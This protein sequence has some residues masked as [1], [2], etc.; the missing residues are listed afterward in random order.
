MIASLPF[1]SVGLCLSLCA[2]SCTRLESMERLIRDESRASH[3]SH[4]SK[5]KDLTPPQKKREKRKHYTPPFCFPEERKGK[6]SFGSTSGPPLILS[7]RI[8]RKEREAFIFTWITWGFYVNYP[9]N[10]ATLLFGFVWMGP[11]VCVCVSVWGGYN[12]NI[13]T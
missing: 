10:V 5:R 11:S 9:L 2:H 12:Q 1:Q 13:N 7:N 4:S 8:S 6:K 3:A